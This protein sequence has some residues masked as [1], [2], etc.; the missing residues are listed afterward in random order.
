MSFKPNQA[1]KDANARQA[2][3]ADVGLKNAELATGAGTG[4]LNLGNANT[5]AGTNFFNTI[6]NGNRA[7][8]TALMAPNIQAARQNA[9]DA[10]SSATN[11]SPRGGGRTGSLF[12]TMLAPNRALTEQ[13]N[14]F[15]GQAA[16][17]LTQVGLQQSGQGAGLM[18]QG[19]QGLSL[20]A[21][22]MGDQRDYQN[23]LRQQSNQFWS[24]LGGGLFNLATIPLGGA[25]GLGGSSTALGKLGGLFKF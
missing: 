3:I 9:Q 17:Q 15:R 1:E 19:M 18:G 4:M 8:T 13:F 20:P 12:E 21:N 7:N 23:K 14:M 24:G 11:L 25:T 6:L 16:P 10:L 22:I 2:Q 5:Q